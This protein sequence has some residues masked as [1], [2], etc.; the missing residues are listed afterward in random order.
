[1]AKTARPGKS[2]IVSQLPNVERGS[3]QPKTI[4]MWSVLTE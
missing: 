3:R 1:M 2:D 4:T